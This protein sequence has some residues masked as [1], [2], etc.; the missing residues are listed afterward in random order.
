MTEIKKGVKLQSNGNKLAA[1][2]EALRTLDEKVSQYT[3]KQDK[4]RIR[5][6][7]IGLA[8]GYVLAN[9]NKDST[10]KDIELQN[11]II[12]KCLSLAEDLNFDPDTSDDQGTLMLFGV[13]IKSIP[14]LAK[15]YA[16][17]KDDYKNLL[18]KSIIYKKNVDTSVE[19]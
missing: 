18:E 6:Q 7:E 17:L 8:L 2:V 9:Q 15:Q 19:A 1:H 13:L 10:P 12:Q 14:Q 4:Y 11:L 16:E 5:S 3:N